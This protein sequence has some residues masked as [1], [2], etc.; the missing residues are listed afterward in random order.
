MDGM[1]HAIAAVDATQTASEIRSMD[2]LVSNSL[3]G[4]R[5]IVWMLGAFA[6][7]ALLLAAIGVYALISYI[8]AQRTI[9]VGVRMALGAQRHEVL[10]MVLKGSMARIGMGLAVGICLSAGATV[11]LQHFFSGM[12]NGI[13]S[14]L[15]VA[16]C[17][18]LRRSMASLIP[19]A[20]AA[21][22]NPIQ[23]LRNE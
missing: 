10:G 5:L 8:T 12:E 3:A 22:I 2:F 15:V 17:T 11:L 14:S 16:G 20:R 13:A 4:R 9:E 6:V 21:S 18:L 1:Q 7:V 23:A 19:A